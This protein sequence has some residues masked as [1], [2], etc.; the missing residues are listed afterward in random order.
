MSYVIRRLE[1]GIGICTLILLRNVGLLKF[2][3]KRIQRRLRIT[4]N[5]QRQLRMLRMAPT[6]RERE[7]IQS[8]QNSVKMA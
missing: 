1:R 5:S 3:P 7:K 8:S 4:Q 2:D 6:D